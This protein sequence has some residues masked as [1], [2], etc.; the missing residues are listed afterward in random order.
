MFI[1]IKSFFL[2]HHLSQKEWREIEYFDETWKERLKLMAKYIP[3]DVTIM[4][5]GCGLMWLKEFIQCKAYYPVD[6]KKRNEETIVCDFNKQEFPNIK[7]DYIFIAGCMEY[8]KN[9]TW[10][11]NKIS[12]HSDNCV[13]SY[14]CTDQFQDIDERK[15]LSWVN[16]LSKKEIIN[17]FKKN[18]MKLMAEDKYLQ[19]NTIFVFVKKNTRHGIY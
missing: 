19:H 14:C 18:G 11:V 1:K 2:K 16:H 8:V 9:A 7:S 6:Y 15:K 12:L 4:D 17:L 13:M 3:E 10:F 5:L